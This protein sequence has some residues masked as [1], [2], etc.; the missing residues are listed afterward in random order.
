MSHAEGAL[1]I[2]HNSSCGNNTSTR[3]HSG[4]VV[5]STATLIP[6]RCTTWQSENLCNKLT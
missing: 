4:M 3:Q 1:N 6:Q 5:G 2:S